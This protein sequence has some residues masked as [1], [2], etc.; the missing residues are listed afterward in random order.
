M[1]QWLRLPVGLCQLGGVV[2]LRTPGIHAGYVGQMLLAASLWDLGKASKR[3]LSSLEVETHSA[4]GEMIGWLA[5]AQ[6]V[7]IYQSFLWGTDGIVYSQSGNSSTWNR[8]SVGSVFIERYVTSLML[9]ND[10]YFGYFLAGQYFICH[11]VKCGS[12]LVIYGQLEGALTR[13]ISP[14]MLSL[15]RLT[16]SL[17]ATTRGRALG[18]QTDLYPGL[19]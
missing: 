16:M 14:R 4:V 11:A 12:T 1:R 17:W 9:T 15:L 8:A 13:F 5:A 19:Q 6:G 10:F 2:C 3:K 18:P 7:G